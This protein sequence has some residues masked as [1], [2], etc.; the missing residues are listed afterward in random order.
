MKFFIH[1]LLSIVVLV[2]GFGLGVQYQSHLESLDQV[3]TLVRVQRAKI[4]ELYRERL[5]LQTGIMLRDYLDEV[6]VRLPKE[7][8]RDIGA[9][10]ASASERYD[11]PPEMILA[12]IRIESTFDVAARSH[13]GAVGLMQLLPS[14][15]REIAQE[16]RMDWP[17][18]EILENP[19]TNIEM[20]TY[21][22]TKLLAQFENLAVALAAYNHGPGR[23]ATLEA[24]SADLP[25]GYTEKV[26]RHYQP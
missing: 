12:I 15:A 19:A 13:K 21:Y 18:A 1:M 20:G 17:G 25:M 23:I 4:D 10:I 16:L 7:T 11:V 2:T 26:L 22:L 3:Q 8:M 9:S 6:Q 14:T 5:E 24:A